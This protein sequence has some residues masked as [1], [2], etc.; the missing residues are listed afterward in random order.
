MPSAE[1]E[2]D[3]R[4]KPLQRI[5]NIR[6]WQQRLRVRHEAVKQ[7]STDPSRRSLPMGARSHTHFVMRSSI[8]LGSKINVGSTTRLRSA[9]GRSCEMMCERTTHSIISHP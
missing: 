6:H 4:H 7:I 9:P 3:D 8:L 5:I 2:L 1:V